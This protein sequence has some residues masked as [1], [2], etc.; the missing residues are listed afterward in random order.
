MRSRRRAILARRFAHWT[1]R[2]LY[3]R[4]QLLIY[5]WRNPGL[6][7]LTRQATEFLSEWLRCSD[8]GLEWGSGRSTVG[9][10]KR[11]RSLVSLEHDRHWHELVRRRLLDAECTN[12]DCFFHEASPNADDPG[13]PYVSCVADMPDGSFDFALVDGI[14]RDH[15]VRTAVRKVSPGG[16]LVLDNINW[17]LPKSGRAPASVGQAGAP[18]TA[19][20]AEVWAELDN[21]RAFWTSNG[22]WDTAIFFRPA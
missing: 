22:V 16:I 6:P 19:A 1:A 14:L 3:D 13:H 17:Y 21:W 15:C 9:L 7:W 18:T 8:R 12:V 10:A 5:E 20:W 4:A 11:V 2:Y